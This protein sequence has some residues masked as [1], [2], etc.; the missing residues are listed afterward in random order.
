MTFDQF[1]RDAHE[2]TQYLKQHFSKE[3]IYLV[4]HS[5]GSQL[6]IKLA[7]LYPED[8]YAYVGVCQVVGNDR[9]N[10]IAYAWLKEE[11]NSK[12]NQK[13]IRELEMIGPPPYTDHQTFVKFIKLVDSYGGSM[14]V[15]MLKLGLV[16]LGSPEYRLSDYIAWIRGSSRGSGPMWESLESWDITREIPAIMVPI[17]FFSGKNDY[18]TPLQMVDEYMKKLDAPKGKGLVIFEKS[19]HAPFMSEPE[20][21]NMEL[22]RVK[23]ITYGLK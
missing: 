15:G 8:Y 2:L 21:F 14:D 10:E 12:G 13:D 18:N 19:S 3:K 1:L 16:A 6:G 22:A 9:N 7:E 23:D 17:Y 4:G 5:W 11:I 20:R